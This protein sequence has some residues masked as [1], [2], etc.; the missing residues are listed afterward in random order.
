MATS[1]AEEAIQNLKDLGATVE[2]AACDITDKA[3]LSALINSIPAAHPPIKGVLHAAAHFD[4][5][6]ISALNP[7][8]LNSVLAPK[9]QGALNLHELNKSLPLAHFVLYSSV[10]TAIGNPAQANYVAANAAL[11]E[12]V[13]GLVNQVFATAIAIAWGPY[14]GRAGYLTR[15]ETVKDGLAHRLGKRRLVPYRP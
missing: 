8:R 4:D 9:V 10:T 2:V 6:L 3:A 13:A 14:C 7:E 15:N 11:E 12:T 5:A 1:G